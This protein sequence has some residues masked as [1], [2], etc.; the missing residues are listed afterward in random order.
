M[1]SLY[2]TNKDPY[3]VY[4]INHFIQKYGIQM[5]F[6]TESEINIIYGNSCENINGFNIQITENEMQGGISGFLRIDKEETIPLFEKP[7]RLNKCGEPLVM[8]AVDT[9]NEYPCVVIENEGI[10]I[11]FDIFN[12]VGHILSGHLEHFWSSNNLESKQKLLKIPLVEYYEKILFDCIKFAGKKL[13]IQ[14]EHEPFW[15]DGMNFAVCLTHDVDRVKE[16]YQYLTHTVRDLKSGEIALIFRRLL[17]LLKRENPYWNFDEIMG[18]ERKF[19]VKSTFFFLNERMKARLSSPKEWKLYCGRYNLNNAKIIEMIKRLD[20]GGWEIGI[21]GSYNSYRDP[22]MLAEEKNILEAILGKKVHGISQHYMNLTPETWNHQE[23]IGLLY[24]SSVGFVTKIGFRRGTCLPF[25]PFDLVRKRKLSLLELSILIMD[26]ACSYERRKSYDVF[27]DIAETLRQVEKCHGLLLLRWHQE[28][29]N[30]NESPNKVET[31]KRIIEKCLKKNAWITNAKEIVDWWDSRAEKIELIDFSKHSLDSYIYIVVTPCKNEASNLPRLIESMV[32]QVI[33]PALWVIVDDG[34]TDKTSEIIRNAEKKYKWI[35][36]VGLEATS[37]K[38]DRGIHLANVM[39][40]GF[41]FAVK[42]SMGYG[43]KF[44]YVSNIDGDII[45]EPTFF[46]KVIGEFEKDPLLGIASGITRYIS[47]G[48]IV[49]WVGD[50]N[51]PPGGHMII[52]RECF[53]EC[54]GIPLSYAADSA[55]KAKA[56]LRGWKTKKFNAIAS[57]ERPVHSSEGYWQGY[58][59]KGEAAYYLNFSPNHVLFN[60]VLYLFKRPY[61]IG[62]AYFASYFICLMRKKEKIEDEE[63]RHYFRTKWIEKLKKIKLH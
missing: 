14:L 24:D 33:K 2:Y 32:S 38:G 8:F 25:Y 44:D 34:S 28:C 59:E 4:G 40:K 29:F 63:L 42:Y 23:N 50:E 43:I 20:A 39:K 48:K 15:P 36:G 56:R 46:E 9:E 10:T 52:K 11:G 49:C 53:E 22:K 47:N 1:I 26:N 41:D 30:S 57:E 17:P 3:R 6:N 60:A 45:L 31:Y 58:R 7:I 35:K 12:E 55:L 18:I 54:N 27:G 5:N 13:N 51:E 61:Y 19:S 16:T 21:H 37:P 62:I